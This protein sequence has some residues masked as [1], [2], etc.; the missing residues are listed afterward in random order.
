M[1]APA[2]G[3]GEDTDKI[4]TGHDIRDISLWDV[5]QRKKE[6]KRERTRQEVSV[7]KTTLERRGRD[8]Q[9]QKKTR[10]A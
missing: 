1:I 6:D 3:S 5:E 4:A 7:K 10:K 9:K 8:R 2:T